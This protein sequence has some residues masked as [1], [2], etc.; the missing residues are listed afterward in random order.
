M[1]RYGHDIR[2]LIFEEDVRLM[3]AKCKNDRERLLLSFLWTTGARPAEINQ[4]KKEDISV[5]ENTLSIKLKTLKLGRAKGFTIENRTL[6]FERPTG[7]SEIAWLEII[8][9]KAIAAQAEQV[10]L[11]F[12]TRWISKVINRLGMEAIQKPISPYHLRHSVLSY[13]A[14]S[15]YTIDQLMHMKGA[16]SVE[17]ISTYLQARPFYINMKNERTFRQEEKK[18]TTDTPA[19]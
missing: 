11:P 12:T 5:Y 1:G 9:R 2:D 16:K 3:L 7:L 17:S 8:A 13:K 10:L 14:A 19:T 4:I 6:E 15:G 18:G